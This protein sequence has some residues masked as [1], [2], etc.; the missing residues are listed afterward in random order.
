MC[1]ACM[2][3]SRVIVQALRWDVEIA[4]QQNYGAGIE[5]GCRNCYTEQCTK[6]RHECTVAGDEIGNNPLNVYKQP[7]STPPPPP[8]TSVTAKAV[9]ACQTG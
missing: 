7:Y 1:E 2:L 9:C 5:V 4:A 3:P 8:D 6:V